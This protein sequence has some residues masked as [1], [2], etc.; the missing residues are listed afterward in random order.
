MQSALGYDPIIR[1]SVSAMCRSF[2]DV[3]DGDLLG[4]REVIEAAGRDMG[5]VCQGFPAAVLRPGSADDVARTIGRC[6]DLRVPVAAQGAGHTVHG[7]RLALGGV[8]I[9]MTVLDRVVRIDPRGRWA[10]VEAGILW[11]DLVPQ[12]YARGLRFAGGHT[13]YLGLSVGG[14]LTVG[15]ISNQPGVGAQVDSVEALQVATGTGELVWCSPEQHRRLFDSA[16]AGLGQV[17]VITRARLTLEPAQPLVWRAVVPF[18]DQQ[19]GLHA[20]RHAASSGRFDEVYAMVMPSRGREP[21]TTNLHLA[22]Y[23]D[24]PAADHTASVEMI[25]REACGTTR[26]Q[27]ENRIHGRGV[28][29]WLDHITSITSI[30]DA[31]IARRKW[32]DTIKIWL[33]V[34]LPGTTADRI[35]PDQLTA[36]G[37]DDWHPDG[38][39]FV[40]V[41]PHDSAKF[42]RPRLRLPQHRRNQ[43]PRPGELTLLFD[44]LRAAPADSGRDYIDRTLRRTAEAADDLE[45]TADATIYPIGSR[46]LTPS[47]WRT[48]YGDSWPEVAAGLAEFDPAAIL[49]PGFGIPRT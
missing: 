43:P 8:A 7:Q 32:A 29:C 20:L 27:P 39:S 16:L 1:G 17:G 31:W 19:E 4:G 11:A 22:V 5:R 45:Q 13:G 24:H 2:V 49:T 12:L 18:T 14:T 21:M 25:I 44:V 40:L 6:A 34:F 37:A 35:I 48:H 42:T 38:L 36:L 47:H 23:E 28:V 15:G 41:F 10:E 26:T 3:L 9:D 46:P 33:D 30:I